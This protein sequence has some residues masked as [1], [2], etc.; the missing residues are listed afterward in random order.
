[1]YISNVEKCENLRIGIDYIYSVNKLG[2]Q[3]YISSVLNENLR[4][5]INLTLTHDAI[6][7]HKVMALLC[8]YYLP[9]CGNATNPQSPSSICS[10]E[11]SYVQQQHCSSTW[12]VAALMFSNLGQT[13]ECD[14]TSRLLYPLPNCCT[15]VG[16]LTTG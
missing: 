13:L 3:S 4:R 7:V 9:P 1:M 2:T 15:G 6:C 14:D 12:Q 5:F 16:F 10:E 11:C 8:Y